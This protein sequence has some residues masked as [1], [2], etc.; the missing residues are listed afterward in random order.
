MNKALKY[1]GYA[2]N[3]RTIAP[4]A[5]NQFGTLTYTCADQGGETIVSI[6]AEVSMNPETLTDPGQSNIAGYARLV[7]NRQGNTIPVIA[8]FDD[9]SATGSV[10]GINDEDAGDTWA[11]VPFSFGTGLVITPL[12]SGAGMAGGTAAHVVLSPKTKRTLRKGDS[13]QVEI[14]Y[15]NGAGGSASQPI[16]EVV[17][18]TLFVQ[19]G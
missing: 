14:Q 13:V 9:W 1:T 5:T 6:H 11:I 16:Q 3:E 2:R 17:T 8:P 15:S 12:I 19:G 7:V 4:G 18:G 10:N